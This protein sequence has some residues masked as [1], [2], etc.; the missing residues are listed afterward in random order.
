MSE[1]PA[2]ALAT[3]R[4]CP[5][6]GYV[7]GVVGVSAG[8]P[9]GPGEAEFYPDIKGTVFETCQMCTFAELDIDDVV[10]VADHQERRCRACGCTETTACVD[11][12]DVACHWVS[13]AG[14]L[15]SMCGV[16]PEVEA[17][18]LGPYIRG[19]DPELDHI[20]EICWQNVGNSSPMI[21]SAFESS[22]DE[23]IRHDDWYC[24]DPT[25]WICI[26]D[27]RV[28]PLEGE[29]VLERHV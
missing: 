2:R 3:C 4:N 13:E 27:G 8:G 29:T 26:E 16:P 19:E 11:D 7:G 15:C 23:P 17:R 22:A 10:S 9:D 12:F 6:E 18:S 1:H 14:D 20:V 5:K 28:P 24:G 25:C 21:D